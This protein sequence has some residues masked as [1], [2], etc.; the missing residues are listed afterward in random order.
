MVHELSIVSPTGAR[1]SLIDNEAFTLTGID[2]FTRVDTSVSSVVVPFVDGDIVT[3]IQAQPR[4]LGIFLQLNQAYGT[5]EAKR[6]VLRYVKPKLECRLY[7]D[8]GDRQIE[9]IGLVKSI[10]LPRFEQGCI[11]AINLHC[12]QPY[13][14][15]AEEITNELARVLDLHHFPVAFPSEGIPFGV[16]DNDQTQTIDNKG[17]VECGMVITIIAGATVKNPKIVNVLTGEFIG[18]NVT[19]QGNDEIVINTIKGEKGIYL[20][21]TNVIDKIMQGSTFLQMATGENEFNIQA[22]SG[23]NDVYFILSYRRLFI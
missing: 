23:I 3:K 2:G 21:G 19:M 16:Y 4:Q 18:V 13:W 10:E 20:N 14:Q 12:S 1:L 7:M 5:E 11:M 8:T 15:D 9:I 6:L 17:D 22:T